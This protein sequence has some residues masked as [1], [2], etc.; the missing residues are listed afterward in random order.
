LLLC[1]LILISRLLRI[2]CLGLTSLTLRMP[3]QMLS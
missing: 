2:S 1:W 3:Q